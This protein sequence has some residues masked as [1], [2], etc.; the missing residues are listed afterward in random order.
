MAIHGVEAML[1]RPDGT[2]IWFRAHPTPVHDAQGRLVGGINM[3]LDITESRKAEAALRESDRH[4]NEFLAMLAHELRNPLAPIRNALEIL[5]VAPEVGLALAPGG[6]AESAL[7]MMDRQVTQMVRLVD[8]LL[9]VGRVSLGKI[10]LRLEQVNL[11]ALLHQVE[12]AA[13]SAFKA[14]GNSLTLSLPAQPVVLNGDP[15][16]LVQIIGNLVNNACKFTQPGGQVQV[17]VV[18][19]GADTVAIRVRDNGIGI[20]AADVPRVFQLFTHSI[21]RSDAL[22]AAWALVWPW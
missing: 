16:R 17:N 8:D 14:R 4:K 1:E 15:A 10:D 3:L 7:Q 20:A 19:D 5:R 21:R 11:A 22:P 18:L 13:R 12:Q 6:A 9:D 2:H